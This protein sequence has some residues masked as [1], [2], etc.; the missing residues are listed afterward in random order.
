[1]ISFMASALSWFTLEQLIPVLSP[2][3]QA[4]A[5]LAW[6]VPLAVAMTAH[7]SGKRLRIPRALGSFAQW[8]FAA[9]SSS[10]RS[11]S[12]SRP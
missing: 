3:V 10:S 8:S 5:F 2:D 6:S 11:S 1:L 7:L 4:A 12:G 9:P